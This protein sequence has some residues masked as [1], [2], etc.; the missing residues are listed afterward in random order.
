MHRMVFGVRMI[1]VVL[2]GLAISVT[3]GSRRRVTRRVDALIHRTRSPAAEKTPQITTL[4]QKT[5]D[6]SGIPTLDRLIRLVLPRPDVLRQ[7]LSQTGFAITIPRYLLF[8]L[9]LGVIIGLMALVLAKL[10]PAL[11]ALMGFVLG[12]G[13][14]HIVIG[15]L[16]ARRR[17]RF[18]AQL[19]EA[20]D[21]IVRGLKSGLPITESIKTVATEIPDPVGTEFKGVVEHLAVGKQIEEAMWLAAQRIDAPEFRFFVVSISVQ[22]ETGGN[23]A[24]TLENLGDILRKRRQMKLKIKALSSEAKASAMILGSLP[25]VMF[26]IIYMVNPDYISLLFTDQR[27][28]IMLGIGLLWLGIGFTTMARM[29]KFEI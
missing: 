7:R 28:N 13:L 9:I 1:A 22:R 27:G 3:T 26:G 11:A 19:P 4:R 10:P 16:A 21:L 2:A 5:T 20:I 14:P 17:G 12:I 29:V 25:F 23:L 6:H 18:L 8:N 24:E 15:Q